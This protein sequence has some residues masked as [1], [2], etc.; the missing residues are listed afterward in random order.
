[1]EIEIKHVNF[2]DGQFLQQSEFIEEQLYHIH[3]RRKLY[4]VLFDRDGVL[5][6]GANDLTIVPENAADPA[7]KSFHV[8]AGMAI[9]LDSAAMERKEIIL[10]QD[11]AVINLNTQGFP[12]AGPT[13]FVAIHYEEQGVAIPPSAGD[14]AGNTRILENAA[15]TV[16]ASDP[17]GTN[18][19]NGHPFIVLGAIT[20]ATMVVNTAQRQTAQI[21]G[22]LLGVAPQPPQ[23][24]IVS[25]SPGG[26]QPGTTFN[27]TITG[28]NLNGAT[29]V[30]FSGTGVTALIQSNPDPQ[31]LIVAITITAGATPGGRTFEV[32][33]PQGTANSTGVPGAAFTVSIATPVVVASFTPTTQNIST[34]AQTNTIIVRGTNIRNAANATGTIV[35]FVDPA[36]PGTVFATSPNV[37]FL[38]DAAALQRLTV[39]IPQSAAFTPAPAPGTL[40]VRVQVEFNSGVGTST[41]NLNILV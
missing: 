37:A 39:T 3:M 41:T 35:R 38:P 28:T 36:N 6:V 8:R 13:A 32:L 33:T 10:R 22:S 7:N 12:G 40:P 15:I 34:V 30:N 27:A 4:F 23:A 16:H 29:G 19:A 26:G 31:T 21:R 24:S 5:Q 18:A 2:F 17:T 1:M 11:S 20:F 25:I 9:S 14:V